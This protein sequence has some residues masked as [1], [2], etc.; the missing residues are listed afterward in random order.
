MRVIPN[1]FSYNA[2]ISAC[3][4]GGQWQLALGLLSSMPD[5]RVTPDKISYNA[6]ISACEKGGQW[7]LALSLLSSMPETKVTPDEISYCAVMESLDS[8][9]QWLA[10]LALLQEMLVARLDA[11]PKA[12]R[13]AISAC[14]RAGHWQEALWA[15]GFAAISE[16]TATDLDSFGILLMECEQ[17]DLLSLDLSMSRRLSAAARQGDFMLGLAAVLDFSADVRQQHQQQQQQ[18]QQ[19]QQQQHQQQQQQQQHQQLSPGFLPPPSLLQP[20]LAGV[21]CSHISTRSLSYHRELALLRY[22]LEAAQ[23]GS[24]AAVAEAF[25]AFGRN[26]GSS[27]SWAKFAGGS[28][29]T[30]LLAAVR[31]GPPADQ[32][33]TFGVLEIGTYCGNS[34][35]RLAAA[36]PGVRVTTL[37]LDPILVAIAR[38][39]VAFAGLCGAIDVWTGHSALLIPRLKRRLVER[40]PTLQ[41]RPCFSAIFMDRWG[42]DKDFALIQEHELLQEAGGVLVADNVLTTAAAGFLWKVAGPSASF[43]SQV[44][45]VSEVADSSQEDWMSVTVSMTNELRSSHEAL[46]PELAELNAE[47]ERFRQRVVAADGGSGAEAAKSEKPAFVRHAKATLAR[48]GLGPST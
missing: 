18:Q 1:Q 41:G 36:L 20:L 9:G 24:P 39:L 38:T 26:L 46:P 23:P 15:T 19:H 40:F 13:S 32:S 10:A 37:E 47:S 45:A 6:A 34:A 48:A 16:V 17:R 25:D 5:M 14:S 31:A 30:A 21:A 3:E 4:K 42:Y 29:A 2:A 44:V 22:V 12:R 27:G 43:A 7:Q 35:L 33:D 11:I 8:G 28:K